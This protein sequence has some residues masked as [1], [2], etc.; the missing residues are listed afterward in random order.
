MSNY[1][2]LT[3]EI[4]LTIASAYARGAMSFDLFKRQLSAYYRPESLPH[5]LP[6]HVFSGGVSKIRI[7]FESIENRIMRIKLLRQI[8][9]WGLK[10][11]KQYIEADVTYAVYTDDA[12]RVNDIAYHVRAFGGAFVVFDEDAQP[13][14]L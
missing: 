11:C 14:E 1:D 10:E 9:D 12:N 3:S 13:I 7:D 5:V 4:A 6:Y 8:T 2:K